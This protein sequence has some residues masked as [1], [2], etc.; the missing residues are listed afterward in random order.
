MGNDEQGIE[1]KRDG[2]NVAKR[3]DKMDGHD[4]R[5]ASARHYVS[6]VGAK[7]IV[8]NSA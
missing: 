5:A 4:G 6:D 2:V 1:W 8:G 3:T 7:I